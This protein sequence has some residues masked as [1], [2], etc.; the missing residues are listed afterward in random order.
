MAPADEVLVEP[1]EWFE[2]VAG[3]GGAFSG[4]G[5]RCVVLAVPAGWGRSAVLEE[6]TR[7]VDSL[8]VLDVAVVQVPGAAGGRQSL[9]V[10][11]RG[12]NS[13]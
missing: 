1:V 12:L 10:Q 6:L 8:A 11:G 9:P 2:D 5:S 7:R 3:V 13:S 4:I